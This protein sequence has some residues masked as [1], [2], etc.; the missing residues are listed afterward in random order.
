MWPT[1]HLRAAWHLCICQDVLLH[2]ISAQWSLSIGVPPRV[3]CTLKGRWRGPFLHP[4]T[5][6]YASEKSDIWATCARSAASTLVS[7]QRGMVNCINL[8]A[9]KS[10]KKKLWETE[11]DWQWL[12]QTL[13]SRSVCCFQ[14]GIFTRGRMII[15]AAHVDRPEVL[16]T[17][18]ASATWHHR[19]STAKQKCPRHHTSAAHFPRGEMTCCWCLGCQLLGG[20]GTGRFLVLL[21]D[22]H[23]KSAA[24]W[25]L[26]K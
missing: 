17:T 16:L 15:A 9:Q 22:F 20:G 19:A 21:A 18:A 12:E 8:L 2:M 24:F 5:R 13:A 25:G 3:E 10:V 6:K 26:L 14:W 11:I 4:Q 23:C 1:L 7:S